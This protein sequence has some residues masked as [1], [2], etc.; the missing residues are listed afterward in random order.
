MKK[1]GVTLKI[2]HEEYKDRCQENGQ[3]LMGKTKFNECYADYT[4]ANY[5]T[6]HLDHKPGDKA[7]VGWS[8]STMHYVDITVYLFVGTLPYSQYTY[9]EPNHAWT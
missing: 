9:V 2:L 6:N 8:G 3:I 4:A 5:L 1:V 7:E